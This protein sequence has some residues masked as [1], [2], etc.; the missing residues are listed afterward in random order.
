MIEVEGLRRSYGAVEAVKGVSFTVKSGRIMGLLGPNGAGK[1]TIMRILTAC[2]YPDSGSARI[3]GLSVEDEPLEVK[4]RIGYLPENAPLYADMRV[5][6]FLAFAADARLIPRALR[7]QAI[8]A[9]VSTCGLGSV[10]KARIDTL[11]KGFRQRLGLA[12]A[13]VHDPPVLILDE[14]GSGLDPNQI[15][16]MR[17]LIRDLGTRKTVLLSTHIM[18]E[19][20][21][22]CSEV[23]IL[24]E[25]RIAA[26]GRPEEL[27]AD[28][29]G[30]DA[31]RLVLKGADRSVLEAR[32][33]SACPGAV[34]SE[35]RELGGGGSEAVLTGCGEGSG[36]AVFDWAVA[37]G[38][39]VLSMERGRL[40]LEDIFRRHTAEEDAR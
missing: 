14:P 24:H 26:Q 21:A 12:Q 5:D 10:W 39:K 31:W 40:S 9:A 30:A 37:C 36:E 34:L 33:S 15:A 27:S 23:L 32:L 16:Q 20:E 28:L 1:T 18:Q 3:D 19:V 29:R 2:I 35:Y 8:D 6:E 22:L 7:R 13:L 4:R 25:G 11:S 38:C 17:S